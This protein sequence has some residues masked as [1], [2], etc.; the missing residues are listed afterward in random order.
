MSH[1]RDPILSETPPQVVKSEVKSERAV[2][3]FQNL[4]RSLSSF[5]VLLVLAFREGPEPSSKL[6]CVLRRLVKGS[7]RRQPEES[8]PS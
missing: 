8:F 4:D 1:S 7:S 5:V 2:A 3:F 6:S